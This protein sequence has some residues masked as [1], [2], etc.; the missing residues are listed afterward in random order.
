MK[1]IVGNSQFYDNEGSY[2]SVAVL[3]DNSSLELN[4]SIVRNN[5]SYGVGTLMLHAIE[6]DVTPRLILGS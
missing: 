2:A 4:N 1:I 6:K 3:Y 5:K